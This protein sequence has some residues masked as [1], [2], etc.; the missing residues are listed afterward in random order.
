[1]VCGLL[2]INI[3]FLIPLHFWFHP[4][5]YH[6]EILYFECCINEEGGDRGGNWNFR[7]MLAS[8]WRIQC[9]RLAHNPRNVAK[10]ECTAIITPKLG[11]ID[12]KKAAI[13]DIGN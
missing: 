10:T 12:G 11:D 5:P 8:I 7:E 4:L 1:V 3:R 13:K 2:L 9:W 6:F